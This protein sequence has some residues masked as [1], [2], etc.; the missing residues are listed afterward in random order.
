ML[1]DRNAW[2][3]GHLQMS[4]I[5]PNPKTKGPLN[6]A[7][8]RPGTRASASS[9][10]SDVSSTEQQSGAGDESGTAASTS[11]V[12]PTG[13]AMPDAAETCGPSRAA[14]RADW[15]DGNGP[16]LWGNDSWTRV[17]AKGKDPLC[18]ICQGLG[19]VACPKCGGSGLHLAVTAGDDSDDSG[20]D[21]EFGLDNGAYDEDE[22]GGYYDDYDSGSNDERARGGAGQLTKRQQQQGGS[23]GYP[24]Q[25]VEGPVPRGPS[26]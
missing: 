6:E 25:N 19:A 15:D 4:E 14:R 3:A 16:D 18:Q 7:G 8:S 24:R 22:D 17:R 12:D 20:A 11:L 23:S 2:A 21:G 26:F 10:G 13:A 9:S 5:M 1:R